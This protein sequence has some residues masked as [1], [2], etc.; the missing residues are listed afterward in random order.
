MPKNVLLLGFGPFLSYTCNPSGNIAKKLNGKIIKGFKIIGMVLPVE[1][2][3][4]STLAEKY[5]A[6]THPSLILGVGLSATRG[7]VSIERV[8]LNR[9]YFASE[10]KI[11]DKP[12][13]KNGEAAYF[14][15]LPVDSIKSR[16]EEAGIP[17]E[18]SFWPDTFV[19]NELFYT[20]MKTAHEMKIKYAGFMHL[21]LTHKQVIE[22]KGVH[23][24]IKANI[25]SLAEKEELRAV[26]VALEVCIE[27]L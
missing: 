4:A 9:F 27:K 21:P 3:T 12:L 18:Y 15:T 20:I 19:S 7:S 24:G 11:I 5:I 14:S 8:A 6:E 26:R 10:D 1:H 25:P 13:S 2:I 23:Y 17:S 16:I 22:K